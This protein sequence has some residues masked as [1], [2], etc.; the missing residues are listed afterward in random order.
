MVQKNA[1]ICLTCNYFPDVFTEVK[2]WY[3]KILKFVLGRILETE[4]KF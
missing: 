4:S 3:Q 1:K 2:I